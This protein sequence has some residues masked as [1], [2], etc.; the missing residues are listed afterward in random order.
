MCMQLVQKPELYDVLV[1]PNLYGDIVS[2][3]CAGLVGGLGVAP[4]ANI[5]DRGG[6]VRAGPRLGAQVRRPGPGEPD[7]ADPV[8]RPDAPPPRRAAAA[9][10][11]VETAVREVI[12]EGR[13]RPYDLG[14]DAGTAGF[15]D[16]IIERLGATAAAAS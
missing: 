16:A 1:L 9:A 15:A 3:L 2:D 10:E 12:A 7:G 5:G 4:G 14:G 11:R 8:G 13:T 6:G